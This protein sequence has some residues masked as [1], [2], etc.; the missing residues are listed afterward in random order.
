MAESF[1]TLYSANSWTSMNSAETKRILHWALQA[2]GFVAIFVGTALEYY[3]K[4]GKHSHFGSP[5]GVTGNH[6]K[7]N[8]NC[9]KQR[10]TI[11]F[12]TFVAGLISIIFI[13]LSIMNGVIG[14]YAMKIKHLI[15]PVYIKLGHYLTGI[16]AFVIGI[17]DS[18]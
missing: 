10:S 6:E 14:L 11:I 12:Y 7:C 5:R 3:K 16:V 13:V 4:D 9:T 8:S 1:L 17:I 18:D 15:K 2:I